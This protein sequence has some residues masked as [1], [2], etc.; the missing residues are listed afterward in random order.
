[1]SESQLDAMFDNGASEDVAAVE[2]QA[3]SAEMQ[4]Q[5]SNAPL[6][7]ADIQ[8]SEEEDNHQAQQEAQHQAQKQ[9]EQQ[10]QQSLEQNYQQAMQRERQYRQ[11][12]QQQLQQQ[13]QQMQEAQQRYLQQQQ[14]IQEAQQRLQAQQQPADL[15]PDPEIDPLGYNNWR[16]EKLAEVLVK[17]QEYID[18]IERQKHEAYQQQEA[19]QRQQVALNRFVNTYANYAREYVQHQ[20]DFGEAY[21]FLKQSRFNEYLTAGYDYT[22]ATALMVDDEAAIVS[23]AINDGVNPAERM[24]H[25]AKARGYS[26]QQAQQQARQSQGYQEQERASQLSGKIENLQDGLKHQGLRGGGGVNVTTRMS[27]GNIDTMSDKEFQKFWA[28]MERSS[29]RAG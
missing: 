13:Q 5:V 6:D 9:Q 2:P 23:K 27:P 16:T 4:E 15:P 19:A 22:Q 8:T 11:Q 7:S 1:M 3:E 20:P 26:H 28:D 25:L 17:Q 29:R 18:N 12:L 14:Q 21:T 10:E 24:Y